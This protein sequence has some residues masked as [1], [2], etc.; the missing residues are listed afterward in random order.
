[1]N[2]QALLTHAAT[3]EALALVGTGE[4]LFALDA[5]RL[6]AGAGK[7]ERTGGPSSIAILPLFGSIRPRGASGMEGFRA[8]I[9]SA[10]D[11]PD[12]GAIVL[13]VDSPGGT[14]AGTSEAGQAVA[15]AAAVKPVIAYVDTL[16]ASAAYW[17]AS[18]ASQIW[19]TPSGEVGS[20]GVR[21]MH[22]DISKMMGDAG[23]AVT[24]ITSTESPYKAEGSP[25]APLSQD[26]NDHIQALA[27]REHGNFINAV[28][29]GRK[30][31]ADT[32]R[33][34]FGKGRTIAADRAVQLGMADKI[35]S[36]SDLLGSLRTKSGTVRRRTAMAFA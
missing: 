31:S 8:R 19:M 7:T 30:V 2:L 27:D 16:A 12:V 26:A 5:S 3:S 29:R 11:N 21:A 17:I 20:I 15:D 32:V 22:L 25:F 36:M 4:R 1:M 33:S 10:R 13:D 6:G 23:V 18:Q 9:A 14:V 28:A 34:D 24:E 35:G